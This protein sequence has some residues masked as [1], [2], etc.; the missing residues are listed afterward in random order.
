MQLAIDLIML[1]ANRVDDEAANSAV[2]AGWLALYDV[3]A[4]KDWAAGFS[5]L[6]VA[7]KS[8]WPAKSLAADDKRMM[9]Q[10]ATAGKGEVVSDVRGLLPTWISRRHALR[11]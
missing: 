7:A 5:A 6:V 1:S 11:Q 9:K 2:V 4:L 8:A 3:A 10:L